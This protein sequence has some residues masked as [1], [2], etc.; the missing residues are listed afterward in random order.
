[1]LAILREDSTGARVE[2]FETADSAPLEQPG[3]S[4]WRAFYSSSDAVH[5]FPGGSVLN[6]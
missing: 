2:L 6:Y 5:S 3:S 1:M 4:A